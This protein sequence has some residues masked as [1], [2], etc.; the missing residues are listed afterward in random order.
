[1]Q[2]NIE[3]ICRERFQYLSNRRKQKLKR[4]KQYL[5]ATKLKPRLLPVRETNDLTSRSVD[6]YVQLMSKQ[7]AFRQDRSSLNDSLIKVI[8]K[9]REYAIEYIARRQL[10]NDKN[11]VLSFVKKRFLMYKQSFRLNQ[12]VPWVK[13]LPIKPN[14]NN[15]VYFSW[16]TISL[17]KE[18]LHSIYSKVFKCLLQDHE[19]LSEQTFSFKIAR[20]LDKLVY[21]VNAIDHGEYN[22]LNFLF[23]IY[24]TQCYD[25]KSMIDEIVSGGALP[26]SDPAILH[27]QVFPVFAR[28]NYFDYNDSTGEMKESYDNSLFVYRSELYPFL[29]SEYGLL[30]FLLTQTSTSVRSVI[31]EKLKQCFIHNTCVN[32]V[33]QLY[34]GVFVILFMLYYNSHCGDPKGILNT[35][36]DIPVATSSNDVSKVTEHLKYLSTFICE[37]IYNI[38]RGQILISDFYTNNFLS[39]M[40]FLKY[41]Y[42]VKTPTF[43]RQK[44]QTTSSSLPFICRN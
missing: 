23:R 32:N 11:A 28:I 13:D 30:R 43:Q 3:G 44:Q 14:M 40:S 9:K 5:R 1:M 36:V 21:C 17:N 42:F 38:E 20:E 35:L 6:D 22:A 24:K 31:T 4:L 19:V 18:L 29:V 37:T 27:D 26:S 2:C 41:S 12:T 33:C 34:P 39:N 15:I 25:F 16:D 8:K 7:K 10:V